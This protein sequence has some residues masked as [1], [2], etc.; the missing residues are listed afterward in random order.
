[1]HNSSAVKRF[2]LVLL[3]LPRTAHTAQIKCLIKLPLKL[4]SKAYAK[5][6]QILPL[7]ICINNSRRLFKKWRRLLENTQSHRNEDEGYKLQSPIFSTR[8][9]KKSLHPLLILQFYGSPYC[10]LRRLVF[11]KCRRKILPMLGSPCAQIAQMWSV[12]FC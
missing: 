12:L 8:K 4:S 6:L 10:L 7:K 9:T 3:N 5:V 11:S 2:A 1:M